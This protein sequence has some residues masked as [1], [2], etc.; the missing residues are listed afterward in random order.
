MVDP[1]IQ[2]MMDGNAD[3]I[4]DGFLS[5]SAPVSANAIIQATLH[6]MNTK[7]VEVQLRRL[8]ND[9]TCL[10]GT[11]AGYRIAHFAKA[12]LHLLGFERYEGEE[13]FVSDLIKSQFSFFE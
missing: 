12:A 9:D 6:Q 11:N 13:K 5:K 8:A 7:P 2:Q 4:V 10:F 1:R 3:A